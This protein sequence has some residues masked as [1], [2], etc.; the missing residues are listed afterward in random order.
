MTDCPGVC[1]LLAVTVQL[2]NAKLNL[3]NVCL[4][5]ICV[6]VC[7]KANIDAYQKVAQ[8]TLANTVNTYN[9]NNN[10]NNYSS[11]NGK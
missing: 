9:H 11:T 6:F 8:S 7:E 1:A 10:Y 3:D 4:R 2:A 5:L